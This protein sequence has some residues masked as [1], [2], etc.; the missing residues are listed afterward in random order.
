MGIIYIC[1]STCNCRGIITPLVYDF[2]LCSWDFAISCKS[3]SIIVVP[4]MALLVHSD[5]KRLQY[6]HLT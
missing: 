6:G 4:S 1:G 2:G 5:D 3:L